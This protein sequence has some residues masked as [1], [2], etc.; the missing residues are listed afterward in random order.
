MIQMIG[1]LT[2]NAETKTVNGDKQVVN[3][4]IALNDRYKPKGATEAKEFVTYINV[5]W[6]MGTGIAQILKKG[7]IVTVTGR[8]YTNA[9]IDLQGN[10]K[11]SIN[12]HANSIELI[13][14][15][16]A[17]ATATPAPAEITDVVEDLP[18]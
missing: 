7:A 11:A 12:C 8:I 14:S 1:R 13:H 5:S 3:F 15:K 16:K 4:S 2:A 10:A 17:E 18:F 9:Y 6:W